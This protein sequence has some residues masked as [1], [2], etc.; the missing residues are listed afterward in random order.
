MV[1][2]PIEALQEDL[3]ALKA[4]WLNSGDTAALVQGIAALGAGVWSL[5]LEPRQPLAYRRVA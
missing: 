3:P 1:A 2:V 5:N 4:Q